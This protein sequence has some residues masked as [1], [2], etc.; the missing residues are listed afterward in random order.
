MKTMLQAA[1]AAKTQIA[2]LSTEQKNAALQAMAA[3]LIRNEAAILEANAQD[4]ANVPDTISK[5]MIDRLMLNSARIQGM[6]QGILDVVKLPDP[7]GEVMESFKGA[8]G[9]LID[10]V[11]VPMGVIG[12]IYEARPNV[13]VDSADST[14]AIRLMASAEMVRVT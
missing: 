12:I 8:D 14:S 2:C 3:A 1:K 5:V 13:T 10:K 6:A 9:L 4:I 7:V 11:R